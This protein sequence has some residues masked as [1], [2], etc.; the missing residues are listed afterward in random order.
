MRVFPRLTRPLAALFAA[1]TLAGC[2]VSETPLLNDL[3]AHARPL[4]PGPYMSCQY[5]NGA[6]GD[7]L[8]LDVSL[9]GALYVLQ[10]READED[11][12]LARF[13]AMPGGGFLAQMSGEEGGGYWY[14]YAER[15]DGALRLTM[16]EC[17]QLPPM[18]RDRLAR[19]GALTVEDGGRTCVANTLAG[20]EAAAKAYRGGNAVVSQTFMMITKVEK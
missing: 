13:R 3:N 15:K 1:A 17:E 16:I 20:A 12:T 14:F 19:K 6:Q 11:P 2:L 10:P 5:E 7:C 8:P 4:K 9:R 18:L